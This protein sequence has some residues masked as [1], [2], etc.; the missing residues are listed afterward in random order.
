MWI[1]EAIIACRTA[2]LA[3]TA[4]YAFAGGAAMAV[5]GAN[6][7]DTGGNAGVTGSVSSGNQTKSGSPTT[8]AGTGGGAAGN[9]AP[10]SAGGDPRASP[11]LTPGSH[12]A[13]TGNAGEAD[14]K[15]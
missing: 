8:G 7:N 15:K 2:L 5:T 12:S 6:S 14:R 3:G 4:L 13:T 9:L 11:A 1:K 10:G